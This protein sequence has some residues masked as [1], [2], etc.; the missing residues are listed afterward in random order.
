M[1][2]P[3]LAWG[4]YLWTDGMKGRK[5]GLTWQREEVAQDG[6]HPSPRGSQKV[7]KLL[8]DFLAKEETARP[9]FSKQ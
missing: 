6:T 3:W 1:E 9:W 8:F 2:S 7:A 4:P 5:D